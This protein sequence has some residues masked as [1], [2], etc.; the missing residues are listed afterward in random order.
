M[1][2]SETL[3]GIDAIALPKGSKRVIESNFH[4][5]TDEPFE[6]GVSSARLE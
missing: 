5:V 2:I 3:K 1:G 4:S 6:E